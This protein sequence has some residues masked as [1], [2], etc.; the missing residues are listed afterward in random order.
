MTMVW[1]RTEENAAEYDHFHAM[2]SLD[3]VETMLREAYS[4]EKSMQTEI[5]EIKE[6]FTT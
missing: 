2:L 4:R 6:R 3:A 5:D 1:K